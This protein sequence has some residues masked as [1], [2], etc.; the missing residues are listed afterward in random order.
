MLAQD[1]RG[2]VGGVARLLDLSVGHPRR[3][4]RVV[5]QR[6]VLALRAALPRDSLGRRVVALGV[7]LGH[8]LGLLARDAA[9][10]VASVYLSSSI[11]AASI[12]RSSTLSAS[13]S[14]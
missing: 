4:R 7:R 3:R 5:A 1:H 14:V 9:H 2:E 10:V 12:S 8:V 11:S 6:S 13:I